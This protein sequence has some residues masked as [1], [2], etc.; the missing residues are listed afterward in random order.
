MKSNTA[1]I[2]IPHSI[3]KQRVNSNYITITDPQIVTYFKE[4]P[5]LEVETTILVFVNIMKKLS[6]NLS[7]TMNSTTNS[8]IINTLTGLTTEVNTMKRDMANQHE[9]TMVNLVSKFQ[10]FKRDY[11]E[12]LKLNISNASLTSHEKLQSLLEKTSDA[13][14]TKT[15]LLI[16]DTI[17][18]SNSLIYSQVDNCIEGLKTSIS[19]QTNQLMNNTSNDDKSFK[20]YCEL[21]DKQISSM[22]SQVQQPI[23]TY[24]QTSEDRTTSHI[25]Q[26]RDKITE[27]HQTQ[28]TI[29]S[30]INSFF[31]KSKHNSSTKGA[32][33]ENQLNLLLQNMFS[34]EEILEV[35]KQTSTC[36][37]RMNRRDADKPVILFENKDYAQNVNSDEVTKF[38]KDLALQNQ[39]GIFLSQNSGIVYKTNF[40]CDI[41]NGLIHVYIP[42][43]KYSSDK[44]QIAVDMIDSL[45][46]QVLKLNSTQS[47]TDE[48]SNETV[49]ICKDDM[50]EIMEE[51]EKFSKE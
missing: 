31:N 10:D 37:F 48:S 43:C 30:E 15:H 18:K 41:K 42:N 51:Y 14:I 1:T 29:N 17:P 26:I 5:H 19:Q 34:S 21:V 23:M 28:L 3:Q 8:K 25:G 46:P 47:S 12:D 13:L 9:S 7:E 24:I 16:N 38:Q 6:V 50:A 36:D 32:I 44:I 35:G 49:T 20:E 33:S 45:A 22:I 39:H 2:S 11:I 4:N 27:Q 40:Q